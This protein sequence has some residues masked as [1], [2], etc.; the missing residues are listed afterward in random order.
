MSYVGAH[1]VLA[2]KIKK[3]EP[4]GAA[5]SLYLMKMKSILMVLLLASLPVYADVLAIT[6]TTDGVI[7]VGTSEDYTK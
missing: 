7:W 2:V 6:Q 3:D 1:G 4:F 5:K